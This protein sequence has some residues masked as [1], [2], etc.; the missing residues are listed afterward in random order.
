M[1]KV[2][3]GLGL[4]RCAGEGAQGQ[5][6]GKIFPA[7]SGGECSPPERPEL[8]QNG[9][10]STL[11]VDG[12]NRQLDLPDC[13]SRQWFAANVSEGLEEAPSQPAPGEQIP[14][15][16]AH[17]ADEADDSL[18]D[19]DGSAHNSRAPDGRPRREKDGVLREPWRAAW[20]PPR[21]MV[22]SR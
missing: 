8:L 7:L 14:R 5:Q 18:A 10:E 15:V 1:G 3:P 21:S 16:Q 12:R 9:P 19:A 17:P 4:G 13:L 11:F 2:I 20:A 22:R 6:A